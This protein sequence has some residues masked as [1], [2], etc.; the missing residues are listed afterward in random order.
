MAD[1]DELVEQISEALNIAAQSSTART[2]ESYSVLGEKLSEL[3]S[4]AGRYLRSNMAYQA[5]LT[6]LQQEQLIDSG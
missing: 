1:I 4:S 6:K 3:E 5:V 2:A